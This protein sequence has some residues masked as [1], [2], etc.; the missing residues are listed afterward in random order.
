MTHFYHVADL[1]PTIS[2]QDPKIDLDFRS[3][4]L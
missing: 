2:V 3:G 4:F 1:F